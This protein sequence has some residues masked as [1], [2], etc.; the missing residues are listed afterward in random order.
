MEAAKVANAHDF[1]V[2]LPDGYN[3]VLGERGAKLSGG[4]RQRIALARAVYKSPEILILDEATSSL[5]SESE[6]IIQNSINQIH[7]KY[8]IIAIAHRLSTIENADRIYVIEKGKVV[9][10]GNHKDLIDSGGYYSK[11]YNKQY[12]NG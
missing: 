6:K 5:D 2:Q 4:Q 3:T 10:V 12:G 1:I 9:E 8:T 11:Y 7:E